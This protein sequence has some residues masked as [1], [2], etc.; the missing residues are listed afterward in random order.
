MSVPYF[1]YSNWPELESVIS[2]SIDWKASADYI[3]DL[4]LHSLPIYYTHH[5][6][7]R[8][9][10]SWSR[11]LYDTEVSYCPFKCHCYT[12]TES[13]SFPSR[14]VRIIME[15]HSP[16]QP[17]PTN[18]TTYNHSPSSMQK[19]S[20][21]LRHNMIVLLCFW[22]MWR[23]LFLAHSGSFEIEQQSLPPPAPLKWGSK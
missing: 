5:P 11:N 18:Q 8:W 12:F 20:Y 17:K 7:Y 10:T 22:I 13:R 21:P 6:L 16:Y 23:R 2:L 19:S 3:K 14:T 1:N 4:L 15:I 9:R